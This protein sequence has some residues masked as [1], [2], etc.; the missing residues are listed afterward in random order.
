MVTLAEE[1]L[2]AKHIGKLFRGMFELKFKANVRIY[3]EK[4]LNTSS[5][6]GDVLHLAYNQTCTANSLVAVLG[7]IRSKAKKRRKRR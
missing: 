2:I 5:M 3:L 6:P 1:D 4:F 7:E